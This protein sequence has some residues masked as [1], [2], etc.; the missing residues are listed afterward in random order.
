MISSAKLLSALSADVLAAL[1]EDGDPGLPGPDV[2]Q[3]ALESGEREVR[4]MLAPHCIDESAVLHPI[5]VD[6]AV[7]LAVEY[8]FHRRR[9]MIPGHWSERAVRTRKILE[10][11]AAGRHPV[12]GYTP[13]RRVDGTNT[14]PPRRN[15]I[16]R[17]W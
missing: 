14:P 1:S 4:A 6:H 13:G 9:E 11:M 3:G 17:K 7:T 16:L 5:L 8:L 10:E 12:P 2:L 15:P